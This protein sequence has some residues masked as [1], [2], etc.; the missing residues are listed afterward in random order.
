MD[1]QK[2]RGGRLLAHDC[3]RVLSAFRG[4]EHLEF[5]QIA[6]S[7]RLGSARTSHALKILAKGLYVLPHVT[8]T[9]GKRIPVEYQLGKRGSSCLKDNLQ[10][11]ITSGVCT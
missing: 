7:S 2:Q 5:H 6:D 1:K 10:N 9:S 8:P 3:I 11:R 4:R